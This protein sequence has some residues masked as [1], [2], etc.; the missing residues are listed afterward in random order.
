MTG[1]S[2]LDGD[3]VVVTPD[4]EP[5]NGEMVVVVIEGKRQLNAYTGR[6]VVSAWSHLI[7]IAGGSRQYLLIIGITRLSRVGWLE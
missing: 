6:R 5:K 3:Y 2:V 4:P 1:D 7:L